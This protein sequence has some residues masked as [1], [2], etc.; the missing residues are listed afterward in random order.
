[1]ILYAL[2]AR[3]RALE[4][5]NAAAVLALVLPVLFVSV[6]ARQADQTV[7]LNERATFVVTIMRWATEK[8]PRLQNY[9]SLSQQ[10]DQV[11]D[12]CSEGNVSSLQPVTI[13]AAAETEIFVSAAKRNFELESGYRLG[14][15]CKAARITGAMTVCTPLTVRG[16]VAEI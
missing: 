7:C 1:M 16:M 11:V 12:V 14:V 9:T 10:L 5:P 13:L 8:N 6:C 4:Y 2:K 3:Q 15:N